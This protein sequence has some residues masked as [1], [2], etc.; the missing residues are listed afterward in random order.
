[1]K[2]LTRIMIAIVLSTSLSSLGFGQ[3]SISEEAKAKTEAKHH[4]AMVR[5]AEGLLKQKA[6]LEAQLAQVG[7]WSFDYLL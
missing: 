2:T 7:W 6:E 5:K 4:K 1:M 3:S